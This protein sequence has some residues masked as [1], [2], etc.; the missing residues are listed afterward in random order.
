M[1]HAAAR[2]LRH[3]SMPAGAGAGAAA[4]ACVSVDGGVGALHHGAGAA[5]AAE[6]QQAPVEGHSSSAAP[7]TA[8]AC[9]VQ[10]SHAGYGSLCG[11]A[12][13]S[14]ACMCCCCCC[15]ARLHA[16]HVAVG[17]CGVPA[18]SFSPKWQAECLKIEIH[19]R[20]LQLE[21]CMIMPATQMY[22][23]GGGTSKC[24]IS[25]RCCL[26]M[27]VTLTVEMLGCCRAD[28]SWQ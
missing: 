15:C 24:T 1:T 6:Q 7:R 12:G 27:T 16:L 9:G 22:M 13:S 5:C 3:C 23:K 20:A 8:A 18:A 21:F 4:A 10:Q 26:G 25:W 14:A 2:P 19:L 17:L 28:I 11:C